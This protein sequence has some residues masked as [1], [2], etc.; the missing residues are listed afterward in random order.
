MRLAGTSKAELEAG[1]LESTAKKTTRIMGETGTLSR[2][3]ENERK[4]GYR[5][6][7]A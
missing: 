1:T 4:T 7:D 5:E 2:G 3:Q 6:L